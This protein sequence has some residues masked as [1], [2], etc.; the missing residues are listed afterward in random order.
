MRFASQLL[1]AAACSG[2][3]RPAE[4]GLPD[5]D[6]ATVVAAARRALPADTVY[7]MRVDQ[8]ARIASGVEVGFS[9]VSPPGRVVRGGTYLVWVDS[10]RR[11]SLVG[12]G[13]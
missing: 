1:L 12:R 6:S 4:H 11:A 2:G 5:S 13:R 3:C 8:F 10:A 7:V 9:P